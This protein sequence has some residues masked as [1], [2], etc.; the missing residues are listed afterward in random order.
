M[1]GK[2]QEQTH[3]HILAQK[4][5]SNSL[6]CSKKR[7]SHSMWCFGGKSVDQQNAFNQIFQLHNYQ[8]F[9]Q[10]SAHKKVR[11][12]WDV[13]VLVL[14][15]WFRFERFWVPPYPCIQMHYWHRI[16]VPSNACSVPHTHTQ[17]HT[18]VRKICWEKVRFGKRCI[19]THRTVN[20]VCVWMKCRF[21]CTNS[22]SRTERRPNPLQVI[23]IYEYIYV[24]L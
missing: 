24:L 6:S 12:Q 8:F 17:T 22:F 9:Q 14:G 15:E 21:E 19:V 10:C 5:N 3:F 13:K 18:R 2:Q 20:V 7:S 1:V 23:I 11:S 16:I 4:L